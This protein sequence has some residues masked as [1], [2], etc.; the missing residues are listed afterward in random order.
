MKITSL[1][2]QMKLTFAM[3]IV[4]RKLKKE[5]TRWKKDSKA[6]ARIKLRLSASLP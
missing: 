3:K 5:K 6:S 2:C 4:K 1:V